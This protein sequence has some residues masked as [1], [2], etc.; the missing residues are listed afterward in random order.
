MNDEAMK[1]RAL[2]LIETM[3]EVEFP[4]NIWDESDAALAWWI[5]IAAAVRGSVPLATPEPVDEWECPECGA[6][7]RAR[8]ADKVATPPAEPAGGL[9]K[10]MLINPSDFD[11]E[12]DDP[13]PCSRNCRLTT[14]SNYCKCQGWCL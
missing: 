14:L 10:S 2:A 7:T 5:A 6:T 4:D 12:D 9:P 1:A 11:F 3:A 8:M 13:T